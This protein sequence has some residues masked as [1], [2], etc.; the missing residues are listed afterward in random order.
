L[1]F[2]ALNGS[3]RTLLSFF[4]EYLV[5][6]SEADERLRT[7]ERQFGVEGYSENDRHELIYCIT[8]AY[9]RSVAWLKDKG[10]YDDMIKA[11]AEVEKEWDETYKG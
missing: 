9:T 11:T 3:N 2:D 1:D 8:D 4:I 5:P 6:K 10:Y 7:S